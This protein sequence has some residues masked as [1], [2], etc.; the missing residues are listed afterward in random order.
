[1]NGIQ[2]LTNANVSDQ[3]FQ[4]AHLTYPLNTPTAKEMYHL[5]TI[6]S[7]LFPGDSC[8]RTVPF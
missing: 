2:Q 8:V 3:M 1:M 7:R 4:N 6:F 5:R